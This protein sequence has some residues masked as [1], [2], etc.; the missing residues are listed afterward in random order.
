[1]KFFNAETQRQKLE[2]R[3]GVGVRGCLENSTPMVGK[4]GSATASPLLRAFQPLTCRDFAVFSW[5]KCPPGLQLK[6]TPPPSNSE[7]QLLCTDPYPTSNS[8]SELQLLPP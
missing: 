3:V 5:R 2:F 8:N 4:R 7:L 1:M 6:S